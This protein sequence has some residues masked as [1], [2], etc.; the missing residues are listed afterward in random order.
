MSKNN[1]T[2]ND[3]DL[4]FVAIVPPEPLLNSLAEMKVV[5]CNQFNSCAALNSPPHITLHMPF[6]W[7][8]KKEDRLFQF[9]ES[10][11]SEVD[12]IPISIDGVDHFDDRVIFLSIS[13]NESLF[14]LQSSL[15]KSMKKSLNLFNAQYKDK[16]FHPHITIAFRD[17][18]KQY[19]QEAYTHFKELNHQNQ[20]NSTGF[21]LL[22][23][24]GKKWQNFRQYNY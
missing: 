9:F 15:V 14:S 10:F 2:N 5:A 3:S 11:Q 8:R 20:F 17:L 18:K 12:A 13:P 1:Q 22:K 19:F 23:H 4:Y 7:K 6:R 24:D 21:T 16:A